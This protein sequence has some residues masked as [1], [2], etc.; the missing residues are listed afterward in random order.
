MKLDISDV[1]SLDNKEIVRKVHIDMVEFASRQGVFPIQAGEPFDLMIANEE[2]KRLRLSG[3]GDV[4]VQI[5]CDRCLQEVAYPF[6]FIIEKEIP[7]ENTLE[8]SEDA[9]DEASSYIDE[10]RVLDVDRLVFNEI[11]VNWPAKVLCKSDCKGICPKCGTNLN[12]AACDCEQGELDPRMAQFQDVFNKF[13]E[14]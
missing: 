10:E 1:Y 9:D 7:L 8:E 3:E 14:V 12:L 4:T 2:G 13:K 6:H 11:L 5:P